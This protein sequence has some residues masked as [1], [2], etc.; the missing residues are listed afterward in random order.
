[1]DTAHPETTAEAWLS[2]Y[3]FLKYN[4]QQAWAWQMQQ[5]VTFLLTPAARSLSTAEQRARHLAQAEKS[6]MRQAKLYHLDEEATCRALA[7]PV[8][9]Q[10]DALVPP[11]DAGFILWSAP[12]ARTDSGVPVLA[13]G[14]GPAEEFGIWVSWWSDT[15]EAAR[16]HGFDVSTVQSVTGPLSYDCEA[17]IIPGT[18]PSQL[19]DERDPKHDFFRALY[20]TWSAIAH[21]ELNSTIVR[22]PD[23]R[24]KQI[25]RA[26]LEERDVRTFHV[27]VDAQRSTA[28]VK[29]STADDGHFDF[30]TAFTVDRDQDLPQQFRW[31]PQL[32]RAT[33][34]RVRRIE[35]QLALR[36]PGVFER[37]EAVHAESVDQWPRW[38]WMPISRVNTVLEEISQSTAMDRLADS[39]KI[40]AISAWRASG[41]P[42]INIH[43]DLVNRLLKQSRDE[44]V[45]LPRDLPQRWQTLGVYITHESSSGANG[46]WLHLEWDEA[47][48][49][50]ELR[51][52]LDSSPGADCDALVPQPVYLVG[53]DLHEALSA[54]TSTSLVR[55]HAIMGDDYIPATGRGTDFDEKIRRLTRSLGV[56]VAFADHIAGESMRFVDARTVIGRGDA[57]TWPPSTSESDPLR[58]WLAWGE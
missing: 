55:L 57:S 12:V 33:V 5:G 34:Q 46:L 25:R 27:A 37:L 23:F 51:I 19:Y 36:W 1:M 54:T 35:D 56:Y 26:G 45:P 49:R 50:S 16:I 30:D 8:E 22:L 20:G 24:R 18:A 38:C 47:E 13:A 11:S 40:A 31:I 43:D 14:W 41:R 3:E 4:A 2:A 15:A 7:M 53:A 9:Q 52:V 6:R 42:L 58:L 32:Y 39:A 28:S 29:E 44:A 48:Q 17:W 10:A 21:G